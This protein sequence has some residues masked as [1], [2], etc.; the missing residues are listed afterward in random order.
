VV[1]LRCKGVDCGSTIRAQTTDIRLGFSP[2]S[3][4]LGPPR[5]MPE[6]RAVRGFHVPDRSRIEPDEAQSLRGTESR[7]QIDSLDGR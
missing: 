7:R 4:R 2:P 3:G 6:M 5:D 1:D